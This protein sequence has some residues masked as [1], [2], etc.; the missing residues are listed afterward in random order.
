MKESITDWSKLKGLIEQR[1]TGTSKKIDEEEMI[2]AL[3]SSVKG[4]D[5][6]ITE[7]TRDIRLQWGKIKR[8]TPICNLLFLGPPGTGKTELAKKISKYLLGDEKALLQF[9]CTEFNGPESV[10]RLIGTP[11]GYSGA[12]KGGELT[13]AVLNNPKRVVLFDEIEKSYPGVFDLFLQMMGEGARLT[14]QGSGKA[15]D[16][17]QSIIILTSNAEYEAIGKIQKEIEDPYEMVKAAKTHLSSAKIFRPEILSRI[18]RICVFKPLEGIVVAEIAIL[19]MVK[20]A[21]EYGLKLGYVDPQIVYQA[22][23]E[24]D[25]IAEFGIRELNRIVKDLLG[26][27][28]LKAK[29]AGAKFVRLD[30][31]EHG[32]L[33]I[34]P[35]DNHPN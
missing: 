32:V 25:K 29:D 17:T 2:N 8:D 14:E 12:E 6:V 21:E 33:Q 3:I 9:D 20:L 11:T 31:S 4:Q 13:R 34:N 23:I 22:M 18:D 19:K 27:T 26:Y 7:I 10:T 5:H 16:F 35:D 28:M 24:N 30:V 15:A 1:E